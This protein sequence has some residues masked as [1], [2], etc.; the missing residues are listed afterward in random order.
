MTEQEIEERKSL[1][2]EKYDNVVALTYH[3]GIS[4]CD[5][6]DVIQEVFVAAY[7]HLDQLKKTDSID[8]W[9]YKIAVRCASKVHRGNRS[10]QKRELVFCEKEI[11]TA[12]AS[13]NDD[14]GDENI[15]ALVNRLNPPAPLIIRMR[16]VADMSMVEIAKLLGMNYNTVKTIESRARKALREMME[17]EEFE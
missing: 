9:L 7:T 4:D 16:Y 6:E 12:S 17:D 5:R 15:F 1:L 2:C 14:F 10:R 11:D 13:V 8:A 3:F